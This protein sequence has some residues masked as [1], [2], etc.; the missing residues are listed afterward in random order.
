MS[1]SRD[2]DRM[3][4][5]FPLCPACG[6]EQPWDQKLCWLC[7]AP[8]S[9]R[10]V[11]QSKPPKQ[12]PPSAPPQQPLAR[13]AIVLS[14]AHVIAETARPTF[15]LSTIILV[16]TLAAICFGLLRQAPG[17]TIPMCV[18]LL[19]VFIRTG[20]VLRRREQVGKQTSI[21]TKI[22]LFA[23]SFLVATIM[24]CTVSVAA[25]LSFC[26]ACLV[27]GSVGS[28]FARSESMLLG[29]SGCAAAAVV[30]A[31]GA[32]FLSWSRSRYRRDIDR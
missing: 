28:S 29:L 22:G 32:G 4:N 27:L 13:P 3:M 21:G 25:F 8:L 11:E 18:L 30:I 9:E 23:G 26:G 15:L 24:A 14:D 7:A 31:I 6:T 16:V 12:P 1:D 20:M 10:T 19:P 5:V 17:L 2:S